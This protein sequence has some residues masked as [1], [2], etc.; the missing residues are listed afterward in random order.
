MAV[1]HCNGRASYKGNLSFAGTVNGESGTMEMRIVGTSTDL[2]W[3]EAWWQGTWV[4]LSGTDGLA[5]LR[6]QGT[7]EGYLGSF[8]YEGN[9]HF[10]P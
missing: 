9:Y 1:V 4:I 6:G 10:E 2:P 3:F 8:A 5:T 7:W